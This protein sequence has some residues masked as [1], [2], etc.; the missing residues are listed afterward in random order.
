VQ[1]FSNNN[2]NFIIDFNRTGVG[3]M[4]TIEERKE[5][6]KV[7]YGDKDL[8]NLLAGLIQEQYVLLIKN[9]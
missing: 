5:K 8:K 3:A 2:F 4:V 9:K 6:T 1:K 7:K